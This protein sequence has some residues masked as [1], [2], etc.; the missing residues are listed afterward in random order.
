[1]IRKTFITSLVVASMMLVNVPTAYLETTFKINS[2]TVDKVDSLGKPAEDVRS[3]GIT[4]T[5]PPKDI[6][7]LIR[8]KS[9]DEFFYSKHI[10]SI[11]NATTL[12]M[13][14]GDWTKKLEPS[15]TYTYSVSANAATTVTG[16]QSDAYTGEFTTI[17]FTPVAV[18]NAQFIIV[19]PPQ[20]TT[21]W[22]GE[23]IGDFPIK[24]RNTGNT[25]W[26]AGKV[27]L[28]Q[29]PGNAEQYAWAQSAWGIGRPVVN[30]G[31]EVT[32][33]VQF[34]TAPTTARTT[35]FQWR[36][37][38]DWGNPGF[39]SNAKWFGDVVPSTPLTW[40]VSE[41]P[42]K[43]FTP[44][45]IRATFT[46]NYINNLY[47]EM[48][49]EWAMGS[50]RD[51]FRIHWIYNEKRSVDTWYRVDGGRTE[52]TGAF[53]S[54][55][56]KIQLVAYKNYGNPNVQEDD[57]ASDSIEMEFTAPSQS[58][59]TDFDAQYI[60]GSFTGDVPAPI[61]AIPGKAYTF[62]FTFV[63]K[64]TR[65]WDPQFVALIL[66]ENGLRKTSY[67]LQG[68]I[69]V[70][71]GTW[72]TFDNVVSITAPTTP[73][74]YRYQWKMA[75]RN[76]GESLTQ[77]QEFGASAPPAGE[78]VLNVPSLNTSSQV[79][80]NV[81]INNIKSNEVTIRWTT[82][83][84][85]S[86]LLYLGTNPDQLQAGG[87]PGQRTNHIVTWSNLTS[88]TSYYYRIEANN[89]DGVVKTDTNTF[90]TL[91]SGSSSVVVNPPPSSSQVSEE[92]NKLRERIQ[93][94]EYKISDLEN[95]VVD[96][97][98]KLVTA[99][100]NNLISKIK[101]RI[102]LQV[103]EN[104]EA[105][106]VDPATYKKYYLKDGNS[107]Y[108]ALGAFGLG[109]RNVDLAK[110]PVGIESRF[111]LQDSDGDGLD[112][113]LEKALGTDPTK[114]DT[115]GDGYSDGDEV[116]RGYNPLGEGTQQLD[117]ALSNKLKGRILLQVE[118]GGQAWYVS[119]VDGKRYYMADGE[120]AYQI[121]RY[122]SLG[123]TNTDLRQIPVGEFR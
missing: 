57:I 121:M 104:G 92:Q 12:Y 68:S 89:G 15:T 83:Q 95:K 5:S 112:D 99:T 122:L 80:T 88:S 16:N 9:P 21:F 19:V 26:E 31:E 71:P 96:L 110:I 17:N 113:K 70:A 49:I 93:Q 79:I 29:Y 62:G 61:T 45:P 82:S 37:A 119:P 33:N 34:G 39:P 108:T 77:M 59:K 8:K 85:S 18:D 66:T 117:T 58:S 86:D 41:K 115:D 43:P 109:I 50:E 76:P 91:S 51:Y 72:A 116:K 63:N 10:D 24:M 100:N 55:K 103:E 84:P 102:L 60:G 47:P 106:Y 81:T 73:G 25:P 36:M 52:Y 56:N 46:G 4:F 94:L 2:V 38:R 42:T 6:D 54:G 30:P 75:S 53:D 23:T 120:L 105:W 118:N 20:K 1:M 40:S 27:V 28:A 22:P 123:I 114:A 69:G 107:S 101:G 44:Q 111:Q 35:Q 13:S 90:T 74:S 48:K 11:E 14:P 7:L 97:E 3:F 98:K 87:V 65:T 32:F 67:P 64:G 78:L